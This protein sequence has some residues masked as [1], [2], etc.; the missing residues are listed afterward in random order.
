MSFDPAG[1]PY[2]EPEFGV[3]LDERENEGRRNILWGIVI[4]AIAGGI[5][6]GTFAA[7]G[8]GGTYFIAYGGVAVGAF[9]IIK[10]LINA[11][12]FWRLV[13]LLA[14]VA[15]AVIG[16]L[17]YQASQDTG[18]LYNEIEVGNCVDVDGFKTGCNDRASV[19]NVVGFHQYDSDAFFPG[20]TRIE[21]DVG[22]H[23]PA[24]AEWYFTP[25]RES[26]SQGDRTILCVTER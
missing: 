7:A 3:E 1:D 4:A 26:W 14:L 23:C 10:G 25:L 15:T 21:S 17:T 9:Q 18:S 5:T 22:R 19:Y 11:S 24:Y 20:D 13:G 8:P 6:V 2:T 16:F 12:G